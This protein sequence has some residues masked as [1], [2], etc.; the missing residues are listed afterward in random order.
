MRALLFS[1]DD[2][3]TVKVD[4]ATNIVLYPAAGAHV[5]YYVVKYEVTSDAEFS[6]NNVILTVFVL[7]IPWLTSQKTMSLYSNEIYRFHGMRKYDFL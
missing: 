7:V 6:E 5:L 4:F 3:H 1:V 2:I